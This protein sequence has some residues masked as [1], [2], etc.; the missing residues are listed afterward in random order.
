MKKQIIIIINLFLIIFSQK[1]FLFS[2]SIGYYNYRQNANVL[3]MYNL[4]K[5]QGF[6]DKDMILAFP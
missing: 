2:S 3:K 5:D 1:A 6:D 4:L